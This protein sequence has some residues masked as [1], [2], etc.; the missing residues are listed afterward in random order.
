MKI[1][2]LCEPE[3]QFGSG[4]HV[5]IRF[6]LMRHGMLDADEITSPKIIRVGVVGTQ[7]TVDRLLAWWSKCAEGVDAKESKQPNLFPKFPGFGEGKELR[8]SLESD[9]RLQRIISR[10]DLA[11]V[12]S[13]GNTEESITEATEVLLQEMEYLMQTARPD[14]LVCALP[15]DM[16]EITEHRLRADEDL[17]EETDQEEPATKLNLHHLLKAKAMK[18]GVPIQI[19]KPSTY[20]LPCP[21]RLAKRRRRKGTIQDEATRAWNMYIA[22]YYKAG[23][24]PWRLT[25]DPTA[26][27]TCF[28]GISFYRSLDEKSLQTSVAQVFNER[29]EGIIVRGGPA[30]ITREDRQPHLT[31]EDAYAL[32]E[33]ALVLYRQEHRTMPARVV[34]HKSSS[35]TDGEIEGFGRAIDGHGVEVAD[36]MNLRPSS[37]RLLRTGAYPPVRG[38]LLFLDDATCILYTKGSVPFFRTY[39]G[40][41]LPR[42]LEISYQAID[43]GLPQ[44]LPEEI[45]ALT[46]MNWNNTQFDGGDPITLA[47]ARRVG[48]IL[49]YIDADGPVAPRYS[50]YM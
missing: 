20:G 7:E 19:I 28:V 49:K 36:F 15:W 4:R 26:L 42:P 9:S 6:G 17:H 34:L 22:L 29:G 14:V 33:S 12:R 5:D 11:R 13:V 27:S 23:G 50:F 21:Q 3:L 32:I 25:R 39:P 31:S 2:L 45:L 47:A 10:R 18:L 43:G 44:L 41:Y 48:A 37:L 16:L 8:A 46:K 38:T 1:D 40:M 35:Y 30:Q 24:R